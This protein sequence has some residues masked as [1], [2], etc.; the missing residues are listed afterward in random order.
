[1]IS[2]S[3]SGVSPS[4]SLLSI[5]SLLGVRPVSRHHLASSASVVSL[6][7][8]RC[9]AI[10]LPPQLWYLVLD[11]VFRQITLVTIIS[12]RLYCRGSVH[13]LNLWGGRER[14]IQQSVFQVEHTLIHPGESAILP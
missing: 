2:W 11:S 9:F 13:H 3:S 5:Y 6:E 10:T 14:L 1:M 4:P 12:F 7:F 8:D